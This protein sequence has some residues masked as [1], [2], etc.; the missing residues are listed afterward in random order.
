MNK[1]KYCK[2]CILLSRRFTVASRWS[3]NVLRQNFTVQDT[4]HKLHK[5]E[6][7]RVEEKN[8]SLCDLFIYHYFLSSALSVILVEIFSQCIVGTLETKT[9]NVLIL[10]ALIQFINCIQLYQL[11]A[12][13]IKLKRVLKYCSSVNG[14]R[15]LPLWAIHVIRTENYKRKQSRFFTLSLLPENENSRARSIQCIFFRK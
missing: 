15:K 13:C 4:Q 9:S 11:Y 8:A 5:V 7:K 1:W 14:I 12:L 2:L 10:L 3:S 6:M